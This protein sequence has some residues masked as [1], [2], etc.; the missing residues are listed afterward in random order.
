MNF[1]QFVPR[2]LGKSSGRGSGDSGRGS[3][4][5]ERC[6][7][8]SRRG[9]GDSRRGSGDSRRGS[10]DSRRGSGD[11]GRVFGDFKRGS[12]RGSGSS[13]RDSD[14]SGRGSGDSGRGFGD[15]RR[16]SGSSRRGSGEG[17]GSDCA[18]MWTCSASREYGIKWWDLGRSGGSHSFG[19]SD[20]CVTGEQA[21][22]SAL[23]IRHDYNNVGS[24]LCSGVTMRGTGGTSSGAT[25]D[26]SSRC[27]GPK[28]PP[29]SWQGA[30]LLQRLPSHTTNPYTPSIV[31]TGCHSRFL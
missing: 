9:S 5:S 20:G 7:T 14:N 8:G 2:P 24:T 23:T 19:S 25:E 31:S 21:C 30:E 3:R 27:V 10:G 13:G 16:G 18:P 22:P 11:S 1:P 15:S 29:C 26:P 17:V 12:K 28:Y 6:S 4:D